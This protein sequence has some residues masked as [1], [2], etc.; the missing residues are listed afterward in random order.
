MAGSVYWIGNDGNIWFKSSDGVKNV[1][2]PIGIGA[3]P[4][5]FDAEWASAEATQINNPSNRSVAPR[6][7]G[8]GQAL[9]SVSIANT[10]T[11]IDQMSRVLAD[12]LAAERQRYQNT[13]GVFDTQEQQQRQQYQDSLN[14]NQQNYDANYMDSIRAGI[15]GLS[16]LM[17][18]LRG[19]GAAGGTVEDD[20]RDIV[21]GVTASDIRAGADTQRENQTALDSS[22]QAFLTELGEKRRQNE[23]TLVNNERAIRRENATGLQDLFT[24]MAGFYGDA[25][26]TAERN[27]WMSRAGELTPQIAS[28]SATQVSPYDSTPVQV[29]SP[30]LT[31]FSAPTQPN[32]V[33]APDNQVGSGIFTMSDRRRERQQ[34]PVGV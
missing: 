3:R 30:Q 24:K 9:D 18:I 11:S 13:R 34:A 22:L 8:G 2:K 10:Q 12:A 20:V 26:R 17:N 1:G 14:T 19:T 5:G 6:A 4:D 21:G 16:G 29:Q 25:G 31:A 28:N 23:D 15:K 32:A 27:Q 33:I 7:G